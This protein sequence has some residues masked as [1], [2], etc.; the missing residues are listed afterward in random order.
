MGRPIVIPSG[1]NRRLDSWKEIAGFFG[2][3]ERTVKRWE[4]E[5]G[6]PVHR[7]PGAGKAGVFAYTD[8]LSNWLK[9][10]EPL[11]PATA[12]VP[13]GG[14]PPL[15]ESRVRW[16][17]IAA[18]ASVALAVVAIALNYPVGTR[19][20]AAHVTNPEAEDLYLKGRYYWNKRTP[21]D[22]NKAVDLFTQ[23][24][25][26]DPG[27]ARAYAGLADTY[28]LLREFSLMPSNQAFSRS[29]AAARRAVELDGGLADAHNSLA[30]ASFYGAWD[31]ASAEREFQRA[32]E[33]DPKY[34]T[35]YHWYA[36]AL[37]CLGRPDEALAQIARARQLD[38]NS[39]PILADRGFILYG[40]GRAAEA[41][42]L[43]Q[44]MAS[45]DPSFQSP[46]SYLAQIS[47]I[48]GTYSDYLKEGRLRA[49]LAHDV[50]GLAVIA[51]G[52]QGWTAGGGRGLLEAT[53]QE[54]KTLCS[55]DRLPAY[56]V[57]Q[58]AALLGR[59]AEALEYLHAALD[60][61]EM[62]LVGL[63]IDPLFAGLRDEP[64]FREIVARVGLAGVKQAR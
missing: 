21:D 16:A 1:P 22:L 57:A 23:A 29:L 18:L 9:P 47:L 56:S 43:L 49:G 10:P 36:N 12:A 5:R 15:R 35:A 14:P 4:K 45:A 3:D 53:L 44:E 8:E 61:H 19:R 52:E 26:H 63:A 33:L 58:I 31:F 39:A 17:T 27:Y 34:A 7:L 48:R 30:F 62:L 37:L 42:E 55:A 32:I 46:H 59:K 60:K 6:L 40:A 38:P 51:A 64:R 11:N 50:D 2:R 25:V 24:I 41:I 13:A 28:N 20:A 54:Q